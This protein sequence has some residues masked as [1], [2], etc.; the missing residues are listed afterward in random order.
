MCAAVT[1][2]LD[3]LDDAALEAAMAWPSV[4]GD[5]HRLTDGSIITDADVAETHPLYE[6]S[7]TEREDVLCEGRLF[8]PVSVTPWEEPGDAPYL[9]SFDVIAS[10][11]AKMARVAV[12]GYLLHYPVRLDDLLRAAEFFG[13]YDDDPEDGETPWYRGA[14][15]ISDAINPEW[16]DGRRGHP[17]V[18]L[19]L[20]GLVPVLVVRG[21]VD[22]LALRLGRVDVTTGCGVAQAEVTPTERFVRHEARA[23]ALD[24]LCALPGDGPP[25]VI[26]TG[27]EAF[28]AIG[29]AGVIS[30]VLFDRDLSG[31]TL[32]REH[33]FVTG[34]ASVE[35][36]GIRWI[37]VT[38]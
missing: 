16:R 4:F 11:L 31:V 18:T 1:R 33:P 13:P 19:P 38:P 7:S 27:E 15:R 32:H 28:D 30:A 2:T 10:V 17:I 36:E 22:L 24:R 35:R 12:R 21:S 6:G 3:I 8:G 26:W 9:H 25:S 20:P 29:L 34:R 37:E 14:A 5:E 23:T